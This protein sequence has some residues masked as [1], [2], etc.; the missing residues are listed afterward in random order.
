MTE[1]KVNM[2]LAA[3]PTPHGLLIG[4]DQS[5]TG[6]PWRCPGDLAHF[7][8][9]T[10]GHTLIV[11]R[12]TYEKLPALEN[13]RILVVS[14]TMECCRHV[15]PVL[16]FSTVEDA[17][18]YA[19]EHPFGDGEV[20][21]AGGAKLYQSAVHL[22][23]NKVYFTRISL[24]LCN[25][26]VFGLLNATELDAKSKKDKRFTFLPFE[27]QILATTDRVITNAVTDTEGTFTIET[28]EPKDKV[29]EGIPSFPGATNGQECFKPSSYTTGARSSDV[30]TF[31]ELAGDIGKLV[32]S[33][34]K[35]YGSAFD[36]A[37]QFLR[38]LYPNGVKPEQFGDMLCV[39]RIFDKLMRISTNDKGTQEGL[40]DAY[41]DITG[42]G[43][44]GLRRAKMNKGNI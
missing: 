31:E 43:L 30:P 26:E 27:F 6:L 19:K 33:K 22:V 2:I 15:K 4:D 39:V 34:N 3:C 10:T 24:G 17:L 42:Y 12:K 11:G 32:S 16:F 9:V 38:I 20:F 44:L 13:R 23:N 8:E 18:A 41:G 35:A 21:I 5:K 28:W 7:K 40:E 36:K 14:R 29:A 25:N 1:Q 37:D